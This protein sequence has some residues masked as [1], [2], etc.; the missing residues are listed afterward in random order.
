[1]YGRFTS[2]LCCG[3]VWTELE[4]EKLRA[5]TERYGNAETKANPGALVKPAAD[6]E[7]RSTD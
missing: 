3:L 6:A 4:P 2:C 5:F 7:L 1:M